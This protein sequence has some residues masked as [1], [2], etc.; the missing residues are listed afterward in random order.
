MSQ[1]ALDRWISAGEVPAVMTPSGRKAVPRHLV[2][3]LVES[4]EDLERRGI[5]RHRLAA[6]LRQRRPGPDALRS[7]L[8]SEPGARRARSGPRDHRT[9]E[10]RGRAY[11][12]AVAARLDERLIR[13]ARERLAEWRRTA[14]IHPV[15]AKQWEEVLSQ[16]PGEIA[17]IVASDTPE[18]RALRQS[19]PFA[20]ALHENER[21]RIIEAVR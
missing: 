4:I 5:H 6:A 14:G 17:R 21:R 19:S 16:P 8:P 13:E 1:T 11:H 3:D 9:A 15:Y 20:G 12:Q 10:R 2:I 7:V 18:A